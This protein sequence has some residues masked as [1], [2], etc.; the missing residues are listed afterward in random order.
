MT[1]IIKLLQTVVMTQDTYGMTSIIACYI[2]GILGHHYSLQQFDDACYT[3]G[4]LCHH[5]SL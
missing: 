4:I 3:L 2:L 1:S 5:Y